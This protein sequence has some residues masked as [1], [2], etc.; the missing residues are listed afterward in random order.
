MTPRDALQKAIEH[1]AKKAAAESGRMISGEI[2]LADKL[3]VTRRAIT[4]WLAAG[5]V[6]PRKCRKVAAAADWVVDQYDL[7]PET[8][9]PRPESY[10]P[11]GRVA[12]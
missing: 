12:A 11:S 8:F 9:G 7:D 5:S 6:P 2:V 10:R 1:V 4:K 3:G